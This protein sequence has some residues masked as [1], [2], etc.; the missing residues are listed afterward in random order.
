MQLFFREGFKCLDFWISR[1]ARVSWMISLA[2]IFRT[3]YDLCFKIVSFSCHA[4]SSW[5]KQISRR[6]GYAN[7]ANSG[8]SVLS[9]TFGLSLQP[10]SIVSERNVCLGEGLDL[11]PWYGFCE[12]LASAYGMQD[13]KNYVLPGAPSDGGSFSSYDSCRLFANSVFQCF[14][15]F[16][17]VSLQ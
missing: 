9:C 15:C 1:R 16:C 2:F 8:T 14:A 5:E 17:R 3:L 11:R 13:L 4:K 6:A 7:V 12:L 10:F